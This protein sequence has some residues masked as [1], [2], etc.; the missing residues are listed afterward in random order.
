MAQTRRIMLSRRYYV[1]PSGIHGEGL[2]TRQAVAAG[3]YMGTFRGPVA[4]ENGMHV[5]WVTHECGTVEG[6]HGRN[7]LRYLNH[8]E[9]P[10]AEFDGFD[11]FAGRDIG[12]DE[13]ITIHYGD[14]FVTDLRREPGG[15]S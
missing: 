15:E 9:A 14:E 1:A 2:F 7:L 10:S 3:E 13:E 5:L 6:R 8:S 12:P 11:L 4:R